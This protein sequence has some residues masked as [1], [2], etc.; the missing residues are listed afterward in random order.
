MVRSPRT[1]IPWFIWTWLSQTWLHRM[2]LA[3][4][5]L[6]TMTDEM[7]W[8]TIREGI[9]GQEEEKSNDDKKS[10]F[11]IQTNITLVTPPSVTANTGSAR[12]QWLVPIYKEIEKLFAQHG[13]HW[14]WP[15]LDCQVQ[16]SKETATTVSD[17]ICAQAA[18]PGSAAPKQSLRTP[19]STKTA[20]WSAVT[21][22]LGVNNP[23][24]QPI[25]MVPCCDWPKRCCFCGLPCLRTENK[26]HS[27]P[28][29][30]PP[31][32]LNR[33]SVQFPRDKRICQI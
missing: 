12:E 23:Q 33:L 11:T 26:H 10:T 31:S 15:S 21:L 6:W 1:P 20:W 14:R 16:V 13:H 3:L 30:N 7:K 27:N 32:L 2:S 5:T 18:H 28:T 8:Y 17:G 29:P 4:A 19:T 9:S 22:Y 25:W 24:S